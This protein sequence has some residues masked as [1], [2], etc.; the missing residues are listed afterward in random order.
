MVYMTNG[1]DIHV[2]FCSIEL[3]LCHYVSSLRYWPQI[4]ITCQPCRPYQIPG[5]MVRLTPKG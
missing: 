3:I 1:T 2:R 5:I 4:T